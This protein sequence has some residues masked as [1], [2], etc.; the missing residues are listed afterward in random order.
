MVTGWSSLSCLLRRML[1]LGR[2]ARHRRGQDL[3][4]H[5][6]LK[7]PAAA[8]RSKTSSRRAPISNRQRLRVV[9]TAQQGSRAGPLAQHDR[10]R[11]RAV[12]SALPRVLLNPGGSTRLLWPV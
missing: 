11:H 4:L 10:F 12:V 2:L 7:K 5:L 6:V 9:F 3:L 1:W 8:C